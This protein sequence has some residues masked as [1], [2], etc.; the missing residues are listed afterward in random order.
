MESRDGLVR[1]NLEHAT[2]L[3]EYASQEGAQIVL[4]PEFMPTGYSLSAEMWNAAEP[5]HGATVKWLTSNSQRLGVWLGTSFLEADGDDFFNTFVLT[6][7]D[8]TEAGRVRKQTPSPAEVPFFKGDTGTHAIETRLGRI[9][10]GICYENHLAFLLQI[11]YQQPVD[12]LLMPHSAPTPQ[13][14]LISR[15][16]VD[17]YH[18]ALREVSGR[19]ARQLGIPVV[20]ANKCGPW[21]WQDSTF[22][23]LSS[24]VDSDGTL[25]AQLDDEEGVI[26]A[27]V[28]LDSHRKHCEAP[29]D[30]GQ[31][32]RGPGMMTAG[33]MLEAF[34]RLRY[35]LSSKRK[36]VARKVSS[37]Q[38]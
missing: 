31:A 19:Y 12:L 37:L 6:T 20:M 22:P 5:S 1:S 9:G 29:K 33:H 7:P 11:M 21:P 2:P 32:F 16:F 13:H 27:D 15:S 4:L 28:T 8:G 38:N 26:M 34:G 14:I 10:V 18:K 24:I 30:F 25:R 3:I 36:R 35:Q 23:G 17:R